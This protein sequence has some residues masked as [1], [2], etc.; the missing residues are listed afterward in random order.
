MKK[1]LVTGGSGFLG[2]SICQ[3]LLSLGYQVT[4]LSR[5]PSSY[6]SSLGIPSLLCDITKREELTRSVKGFH[7]VIHCAAKAGIWG[8]KEDFFRINVLGTKN[9]IHSMKKNKIPYLVY[10]SSPS[11][12]FGDQDIINGK[13]DL[14][15][16]SVFYS[17]YGSS[18]AQGEKLVLEANNSSLKT[19]ALRP[20]LIWGPEDPHFLPRLLHKATSKKLR[21]VG[22]QKN[23][24]DVIYVEN[25]ATAHTKALKALMNDHN[26]GGQAYFI[27][28]ERPVNLWTF[29]NQMLRAC[30]GPPITKKIPFYL[31]Y[32]IG[33]LC[34][35]IYKSIG[36]YKKD[37][38]MTRFL[39]LQ[40]AKSH[41]FNHEKA[42]RDFS[43]SPSISIEEGLQKLKK[44]YQS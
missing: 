8:R 15:Y 34:E 23:M 31:A 37:P 20:H 5:K 7:A 35:L 17:D 42:H 27:G 6:L 14:A 28:Q 11:V 29:I 21:V 18:K 32:K 24:V 33:Y 30:G 41:H 3:K 2:K 16:P 22:Q 10:T 40:L 4:S 26:L 13:E 25:A 12:V 44:H 39:A 1:I 9:L 43:Y 19:T 38:P 36:Q